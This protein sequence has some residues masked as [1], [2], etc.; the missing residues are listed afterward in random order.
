MQELVRK[1]SSQLSG[2]AKRRFDSATKSLTLGRPTLYNP[3]YHDAHVLYFSA[4]GYSTTQIIAEFGICKS[5]F[6]RWMKMPNNE[7]F[8]NSYKKGR[9]ICLAFY[10]D[11]QNQRLQ[12]SNSMPE[13]LLM[14]SILAKRFGNGADMVELP[15]F[16]DKSSGERLE[17]ILAAVSTGQMNINSASQLV[18]TIKV[19]EEISSI[20]DLISQLDSLKEQLKNGEN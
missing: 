13:F 12:E 11:I 8:S 7:T 9:A 2:S 18:S 14:E 17:M 1:L 16:E 15:G 20:P 19:A 5:T 3:E 10:H 6:Y 4:L